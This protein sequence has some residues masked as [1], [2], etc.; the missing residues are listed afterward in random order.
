MGIPRT[1]STCQTHYTRDSD[2]A[3]E[4][5]RGYWHIIILSY[6]RVVSIASYWEFREAKATESCWRSRWEWCS[7]SGTELN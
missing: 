1:T 4:W 2:S 5:H 3:Q 7:R 6:E